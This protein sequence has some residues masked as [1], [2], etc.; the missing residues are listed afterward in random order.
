MKRPM[1][2]T[3]PLFI[4]SIIVYALFG[5]KLFIASVL[6]CIAIAGILDKSLLNLLIY[7]LLFSGLV[8]SIFNVKYKTDTAYTYSGEEYKLDF[9]VCS[10]TASKNSDYVTVKVY[11]DKVFKDGTKFNLYFRNDVLDCGEKITADVNMFKVDNEPLFNLSRSKGVYGNLW[12]NKVIKR[13]GYNLFYKT[14]GDLRKFIKNKLNDNLSVRSANT[15]TAIMLGD[16]SELSDEFSQNVKNAGVSHI[17]AVSGLHLSVIMA[18]LFFVI[19]RTV[20]NKYLRFVAV[21]FAVFFLCALCG[22]TPSI[23][24]A[25]VMFIMFA[26]P[27]LINKDADAV[28]VLCFA[29]TMILAVSPMLLFNVSFQMSV[30]AIV[31]VMVVSPCYLRPIKEKLPDS[32]ILA[33]VTDII[34][35][36]V[37]AQIFTMPFAVYYFGQISLISPVTNVLIS[38]PTTLVLQLGF[39]GIIF[40]FLTFVSGYLFFL[41]E[42]GIRYINAVIEYGG[43]LKYSAVSVEKEFCIIPVLLIVLLSA[44]AYFIQKRSVENGST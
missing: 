23:I 38:L 17:M 32:L 2:I 13:N 22:F 27:P 11:N 31:A 6:F 42:Y 21:F 10:D 34:V 20:K 5:I 29:V 24:R 40:S 43:G 35:V 16:K 3:A 39:F 26:V 25:G 4:I 37:L 36:S 12:L 44:V 18:M 9:T 28:S 41:C 7:I 14:T 30:S 15:L 19:D 33:G 8:L 1:L